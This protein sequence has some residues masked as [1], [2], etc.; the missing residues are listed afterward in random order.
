MARCEYMGTIAMIKLGLGLVALAF[1]TQ[2]EAADLV[3]AATE[4]RTTYLISDRPS[5]TQAQPGTAKEGFRIKLEG[6]SGPDVLWNEPQFGFSSARAGG[7]NLRSL[8]GSDLSKSFALA[9]GGDVMSYLIHVNVD[10]KGT[11]RFAAVST[12]FVGNY[13]VMTSYGICR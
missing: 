9:A 2:A 11:K 12:M 8:E 4:T 1:G 13:A 7:L 10:D 6:A 3:C 5:V